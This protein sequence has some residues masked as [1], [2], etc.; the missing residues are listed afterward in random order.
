M[1]S[2]IFRV[3]VFGLLV[4]VASCGT[5]KPSSDEKSVVLAPL[6][7]PLTSES[8]ARA[9]FS[10]S[11]NPSGA[12][13]YGT[14][15]N[16][17]SSFVVFT[18]PSSLDAGALAK[19]S[20]AASEPYVIANVSGATRSMTSV[21]DP[22]SAL[23]LHPGPGGERSVVQWTAPSAATIQ[24]AG[25]FE[26]AA[27]E[28]TTTD[29]IV[30]HNGVNVSNFTRGLNGFG[31]RLP[32]KIVRTVAAGDKIEFSVG[33]GDNGTYFSD[34]TALWATIDPVQ[35]AVGDASVVD[36]YSDT[37]NPTGVWSY[38]YRSAATAP[39]TRYATHG[40][41][42]GSNFDTW[43]ASGCCPHITHNRTTTSQTFSTFTLPA[44]QLNLHPGPAG[45]RSVARWTAPLSAVVRIEGLFEGIDNTTSDVKV[46]LS[47]AVLFQQ[48]LNGRGTQAPFS[49]LRSV[50]AGDVIEFS[51]GVGSNGNYFSDSTGL[52]VQIVPVVTSI[53]DT[54]APSDR[55]IV[56]D[57]ATAPA[58]AERSFGADPSL[59]NPGGVWS[60][61]YGTTATPFTLYSAWDFGYGE[62]LLSW[63]RSSSQTTPHATVNLSNGPRLFASVFTVPS[64]YVN[65]HPG[66]SGERSVA[67]WTAP[68]TGTVRLKGEFRGLDPGTTT[69]VRIDH[70]G[71]AI[72]SNSI[73]GTD[74]RTF[75]LNVAVVRGQ[76]L[77]LSVGVGSNGNYF[78]DSTG[79][80]VSAS[81]P[82]VVG[83]WSATTS[84]PFIAIHASLLPNGKVLLWGK[85]NS[86]TDLSTGG[87][88]VR[89]WDPTTNA[90]LSVAAPPGAP[91]FNDTEG[92]GV[93]KNDIF[94]SEQTVL[95]DGKVLVVGGIVEANKGIR[96]TNVFDWVTN[97]W[98]A[99]HDMNH[100]RWY[101]TA[102]PLANGETLVLGLETSLPPLPAPQEPPPP[103]Q[104]LGV[105]GIWRDLTTANSPYGQNF[106]IYNFLHLAPNGSVFV[107]GP[108]P[109]A[110]YLST[111][112]TGSWSSSA[113]SNGGFRDYGSSVI[114]ADG[115][116][117]IAG[118][119]APTHTA[120][121]IDLNAPSPSF[122]YTGSMANARRHFTTTL[123]PDGTVFAMGGTSGPGYD[124]TTPV[125]EAEVWNPTTKRFSTLAPMKRARLYHSVALLLP[126]ATVM[127]AGSG[128]GGSPDTTRQFNFEIFSPP[129]LNQSGS[130]PIINSAPSSVGYGATFYVASTSAVSKMSWIRLGAV[131]HGFD[132]SQ[133]INTLSFTATS[134]GFNV[135]APAN[136]NLAPPGHYMLFLLNAAGVPSIA[137]I[138]RLQ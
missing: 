35:V 1:G 119:G 12:W 68:M 85:R 2:I 93:V 40:S 65:L 8:N 107:S 69:D 100:P 96:N 74:A 25:R 129:Y 31:D 9:E 128:F 30:T 64:G 111:A 39:F 22:R 122:A 18:Q 23:L 136:G 135:T 120:E 113:T 116:V 104:V 78:S 53:G 59:R 87:T 124:S 98:T 110:R 13:S 90:L 72:W 42:Y 21:S 70:A 71:T 123:L 86:Y 10:P 63:N 108:D 5:T 103:P 58:I 126:D 94:C 88:Q 6:V 49:L 134:G 15:A 62:A 84:W 125:L 50:D 76:T 132:A 92:T 7:G 29:V 54:V 38:G 99:G 20:N 117:L 105:N 80:T 43:S 66:P 137:K 56:R 55:Y 109:T 44:N 45:E 41:P 131:T 61:G 26:G 114:L 97:S 57:P 77:D 91:N 82:S 102:C 130:R 47:G 81:Y 34:S 60:Y 121:I 89:V 127:T 118:G 16:L 3:G 32:F 37:N 36:D 27:R 101:P 11:Q 79:L 14:R 95:A 83:D 133:R 115:R 52:R 17:S 33:V 46:V 24:V 75:W 67:R 28:G 106:E 112:G 4:L 73:N 138:I 19:W 48:D 51:V